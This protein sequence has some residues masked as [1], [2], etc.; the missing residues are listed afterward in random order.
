M[1]HGTVVCKF[2]F[3]YLLDR[4]LEI[5]AG[6]SIQ[7]NLYSFPTILNRYH[8]LWLKFSLNNNFNIGKSPEGNINHIKPQCNWIQIG[9]SFFY[10]TGSS[11][12]VSP[13]LKMSVLESS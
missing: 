4:T 2:M 1:F 11:Q 3:L 12:I 10:P 13:R 9:Q 6:L 5:L 7:I 8:Q